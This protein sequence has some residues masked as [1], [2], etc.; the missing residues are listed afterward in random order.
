MQ[1]PVKAFPAARAANLIGERVPL[2]PPPTSTIE[3]ALAASEAQNAELRTQVAGL[4]VGHGDLQRQLN[5]LVS[6][7][8]QLNFAPL[9]RPGQEP[10]G[11]FP[12][13]APSEP[14][15][16]APAAPAELVSATPAEAVD[17]SQ[18]A[19]EQMPASPEV[20]SPEPKT[21]DS[22][23]S[24]PAEVAARAAAAAELSMRAATAAE[25]STNP[26]L[27]PSPAAPAAGSE[28]VQA[29]LSPPEPTPAESVKAR[30]S[31]PSRQLVRT[32]SQ[33]AP[34]AKHYKGLPDV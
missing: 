2:T 34:A 11:A 1:P 32:D 15:I 31:T 3:A 30:S 29:P 9:F 25:S 8:N 7:L 6:T 21:P 33:E 12:Q 18:I 19:S 13:G 5:L 20:A 4:I 27:V 23:F 26:E 16:A 22:A 17:A 14:V 28:D 24:D 10:A